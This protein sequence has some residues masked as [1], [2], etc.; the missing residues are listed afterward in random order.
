MSAAAD[1]GWVE[2]PRG[3]GAL[4]NELVGHRA[5]KA[6]W[7]GP[8]ALA[9]VTGRRLGPT[10]PPQPEAEHDE[11]RNDAEPGCGKG[12]CAK[13]R[14]GDCVLNGRRARHR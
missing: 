4:T 12:R 6:R 7:V 5:G 11:G 3:G 1:F 8:I 9:A 2:L 13:E 14:H 10:K